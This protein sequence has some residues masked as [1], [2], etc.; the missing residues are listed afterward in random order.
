MEKAGGAEVPASQSHEEGRLFPQNICWPCLHVLDI[1]STTKAR[2]SG[3]HLYC[4]PGLRIAFTLNIPEA[5][6]DD[7]RSATVLTRGKEDVRECKPVPTEKI[8]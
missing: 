6:T 7:E 1:C 4:M 5:A 8:A 2:L 3:V